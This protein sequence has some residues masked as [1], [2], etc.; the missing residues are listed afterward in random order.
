[1]PN[2]FL[3]PSAQEFNQYYDESGSE[4]YY[5]NLI[6]DAMEPY[7][8]AN[9][10]NYTRNNPDETLTQAIATSNAGN[11][12]LHLALHSNAG[13]ESLAGALRGADFYYFTPSTRSRE[14]ANVLADNFKNIYPVPS[15]VKAVPTTSLA[16]VRRTR[17]PAVLAELAYHDNRTDAEWIKANIGNIA[18]NLVQG[19]CILFGIPFVNPGAN[20]PS[21]NIGTVVTEGGRLNIRNRPT[22]N[23]AVIGQIPNGTQ[24]PILGSVGEWFVIDYNGLIGFVS[25]DY[26]IRY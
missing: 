7:L 18:A 5:M 9:G 15:L 1:M 26:L 4:E 25:D 13:P 23:S 16:E 17:S 20:V 10:I 19:L 22:T 12:D 8:D 11:Y 14:A 24:V 6:A 3:S 21:E 2:I